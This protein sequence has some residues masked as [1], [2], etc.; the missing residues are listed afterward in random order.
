LMVFIAQKQWFLLM[1]ALMIK[2][3]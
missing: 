3:D 2:N 1:K